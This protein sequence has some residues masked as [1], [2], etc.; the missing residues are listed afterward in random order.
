MSEKGFFAYG[1]Q[2]SSSG[3]CI[4]E[5]IEIINNSGEV[6][7]TSWIQLRN[8]GRFIINEVLDEIDN[9][10]FFCCDLTGLNDN[11]LFE[12]GYALAR[13]KPIFVIND[14]SYEDSNKK[15]KELDLL[16]TIG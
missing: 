2:Y 7:I 16:S 9:C 12:L 8:S 6:K 3:E 15:F 10:D 11:V 1:S 4:E 14:V 13:K 5:A